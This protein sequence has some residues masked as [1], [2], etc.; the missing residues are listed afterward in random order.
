MADKLTITTT[1]LAVVD[2]R[3]KPT[4]ALCTNRAPTKFPASGKLRVLAEKAF[5]AS[6]KDIAHLLP[7]INIKCKTKYFFGLLS[8]DTTARVPVKLVN[9]K[10][11]FNSK[12]QLAVTLRWQ[13][14][15]LPAGIK[16]PSVKHVRDALSG[17]LTDGWGEGVEQRSRFGPIVDGDDDAFK[18]VPKAAIKKSMRACEDGQYA[19]LYTLRDAKIELK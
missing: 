10:H 8:R 1:L 16:Q 11:A 12:N 4:S 13:I 7:N 6:K 17:S 2:D 5:K 15:S 14:D 18:L 19:L 3:L 9:V